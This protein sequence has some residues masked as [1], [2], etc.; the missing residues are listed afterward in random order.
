MKK[1]MFVMLSVFLGTTASARSIIPT[2]TFEEATI[3]VC[4]KG[5]VGCAH[6]INLDGKKFAM[7]IDEDSRDAEQ[8]I[9]AL[10][11][12]NQ[13][14]KIRKTQP[15]TVRGYFIEKGVFPNPT[16]KRTVFVILEVSNVIS[17]K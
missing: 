6:T 17:P 3:N 7:A 16:V 15:F 2:P 8:S 10:I 12:A 14:H 1:L 9:N 11:G 5:I 13:F 4:P